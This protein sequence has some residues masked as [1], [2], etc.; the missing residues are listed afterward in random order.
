[1]IER[2]VTVPLTIIN[3]QGDFGEFPQDPAL[4]GF[5]RSDRVYVAVANASLLDPIVLNA[6]DK[7]WWDHHEALNRNGIN[8]NFLCPQHM[9]KRI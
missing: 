9:N 5:D 6:V 8:V 2:C 3:L 7:G 4:N 1:M